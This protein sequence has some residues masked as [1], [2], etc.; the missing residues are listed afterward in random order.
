MTSGVAH[1]L[2]PELCYPLVAFYSGNVVNYRCTVLLK[3]R[4]LKKGIFMT[5]S[6]CHLLLF[7]L[8]YASSVVCGTDSAV[9]FKLGGARFGDQAFGCSQAFWLHYRYGLPLLFTPFQY[10]D[11]L[12]IHHLY[13]H[14]A[15]VISKEFKRT[16]YVKSPEPRYDGNAILYTTIYEHPIDVDWSDRDFVEQ[17]RAVFSPYNDNWPYIEVPQDHHSIAMHIR[18]GG[19]YPWDKRNYWSRP[20]Q[21]PSLGYYVQALQLLLRHLDGPCYVRI[22]TDDPNPKSFVKEIRKQLSPF[23]RSRVKIAYRKDGNRHNAHVLNDFFDMMQFKYLIRTVSRFSLFVELLGSC[24]VSMYP[25][26]A[27]R[28]KNAWG[29]VTEICVSVFAEGESRTER[30]V[31]D[32][33]ASGE[34]GGTQYIPLLKSP[35]LRDILLY[36]ERR[37]LYRTLQAK[38]PKCY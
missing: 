17:Y 13:P 33:Y 1:N 12:K 32:Q 20:L 21:F 27:I 26:G 35:E 36:P 38:L 16:L 4:S 37:A 29:K 19:G 5:S 24:S 23:D 30:I 25:A 8:L 28:K 15:D 10:S 11:Q 14:C 3:I 31:F 18:C 6:M 7:A 22:F 9:T 34:I 2:F